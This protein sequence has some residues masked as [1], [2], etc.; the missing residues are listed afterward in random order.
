MRCR[1]C[2][3]PWFLLMAALC[4]SSNFLP[5]AGVWR[6][7]LWLSLLRWVCGAAL[8]PRL[9]EPDPNPAWLGGFTAGK[10]ALRQ[11]RGENVDLWWSSELGNETSQRAG[12]ELLRPLQEEGAFPDVRG[13]CVPWNCDTRPASAQR[14]L[15]RAHR[16][17]SMS[18]V[19]AEL[20]FCQQLP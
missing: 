5:L 15:G 2:L 9:A 12:A 7:F 14:D 1:R 13:S 10:G 6:G 4:S 16:W 11:E 17:E 19:H 18:Q 20:S 3:C 8:Q